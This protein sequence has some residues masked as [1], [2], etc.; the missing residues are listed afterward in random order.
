MIYYSA[1]VVH[2]SAQSTKNI[3]VTT[4]TKSWSDIIKKME[5][6][7]TMWIKHHNQQNIPLPGVVIQE[8]AK[9]L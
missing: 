7:L 8:K 6:M 1:D 4:V 9:S 5:R 3:S 2:K